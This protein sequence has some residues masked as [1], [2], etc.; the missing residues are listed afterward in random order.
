MP[1]VLL[2]QPPIRDF[3]LTAKRTIPYGLGLIA[4]ACIQKGYS[5]S[6]FDGLATS[7]SRQCPMPEEMAY[8]TDY[9]GAPDIS[10]FR[11]FHNFYHFGYSY[12][13]IT[14]VIREADA[15]LIGISSLFTPYEK[16]ALKIARLAKSVSPGST[17][18][19]GGHHPTALPHQVMAHPAIDFV[20]RGDGEVAV[21]ELV[22]VLKKSGDIQ[23]VPGIVFR[24]KRQLPSCEPPRDHQISR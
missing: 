9:Y 2:I 5:V 18:V 23:Q 12:E 16:E 7:K 20:I 17:V 22:N 3:Y 14:R 10:P 4:S 21:P 19:L 1:D 11:L 8:L 6:I 24:K 13:H 15:F